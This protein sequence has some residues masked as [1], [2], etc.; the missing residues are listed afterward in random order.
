MRITCQIT[1]EESVENKKKKRVSYEVKSF[2]VHN[3]L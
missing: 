1:I 3:K 2:K